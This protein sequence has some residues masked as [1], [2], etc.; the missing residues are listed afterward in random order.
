MLLKGV[1]PLAQGY[2]DDMKHDDDVHIREREEKICRPVGSHLHT[3][4]PIVCIDLL[5]K[6]D[7]PDPVR[8]PNGLFQ[9]RRVRFDLPHQL[10]S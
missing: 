8:R 9:K 4:G 1:D 7:T 5:D 10:K 6:P 3:S 2:G